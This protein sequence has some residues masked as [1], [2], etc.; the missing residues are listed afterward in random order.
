MDELANLLLAKPGEATAKH[1]LA[2][3]FWLKWQGTQIRDR[4]GVVVGSSAMSEGV[5]CTTKLKLKAELTTMVK[6]T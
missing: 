3:D 5:H 6:Q 4:G 2:K 1:G